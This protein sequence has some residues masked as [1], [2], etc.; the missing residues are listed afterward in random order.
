MMRRVGLTR[1]VEQ[2]YTHEN[3]KETAEKRNGVHTTGGVEALEE[4]GR[5]NDRAGGKS[6]IVDWIDTVISTSPAE[7]STRRRTRW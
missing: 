4:N 5:S 6:D 3:D 1:N 2:I 7:R